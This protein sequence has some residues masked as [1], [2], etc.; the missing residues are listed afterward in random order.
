MAAGET[1]SETLK[2]EF[3]EETM[4]T[5]EVSPEEER[6]ILQQVEALFHAGDE[7]NS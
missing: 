2:R 7:V 4:N 5:L 3:S 1:V 6:R